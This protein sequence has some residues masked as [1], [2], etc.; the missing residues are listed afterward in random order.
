[1]DYDTGRIGRVIVARGFE[2]EDVYAE[3]GPG[4]NLPAVSLIVF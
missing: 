2:G 1:M 3:I 4:S